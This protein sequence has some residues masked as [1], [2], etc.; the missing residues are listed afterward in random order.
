MCMRLA[1][2]GAAQRYMEVVWEFS[3]ENIPSRE[4]YGHLGDDG[5]EAGALVPSKS[6][7]GCIAVHE[8]KTGRLLHASMTIDMKSP[9]PISSALPLTIQYIGALAQTSASSLMKRI[10]AQP[11][12]HSPAGPVVSH[13]EGP[14]KAYMTRLEG[15][16]YTLRSAGKNCADRCADVH[17]RL[18]VL[19]NVLGSIE[20]SV[21]YAKGNIRAASVEATRASKL[22]PGHARCFHDDVVGKG[23]YGEVMAALQYEAGTQKTVM[24]FL[25]SYT[26]V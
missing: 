17:V 1:L 22:Y 7:Y 20:W 3:N 26:V 16:V 13:H 9:P 5:P 11:V 12:S 24:E 8:E 2:P 10:S 6:Q 19:K 23:E 21:G 4:C 14:T 25:A 15:Q 18:F